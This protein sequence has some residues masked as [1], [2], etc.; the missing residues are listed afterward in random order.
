MPRVECLRDVDSL[1]PL[2]R[3]WQSL[4]HDDPHASV[5]QTPD[6][7]LTWQRYY[8]SNLH[9][10]A[11]Y[12]GRELIAFAPMMTCDLEGQKTLRFLGAPFNDINAIVA[13]REKRE[14]ALRAMLEELGEMWD[15]DT[16][17]WEDVREPH[18]VLEWALR[19]GLTVDV[20]ESP[21]PIIR[22]D[23][24]A[25]VDDQMSASRRK[26]L[27][28]IQNRALRELG[29]TAIGGDVRATAD[30]IQD[31]LALRLKSWSERDRLRDVDLQYRDSLHDRF[32]GDAATALT[33]AK[34]ARVMRLVDSERRLLATNLLLDHQGTTLLYY[35]AF[36]PC[37]AR[38]SPGLL[39]DWICIRD[40]EGR[41]FRRFDYGRG[42]E[43]YKF[44]FPATLPQAS[45]LTIRRCDG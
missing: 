21:C 26:R 15:W 27:R 28:Y 13:R 24:S 4:S 44:L 18:A 10:L 31:L 32:L 5:F 38:Y 19:T 3:A 1:E 37:Y 12:E 39:L 6:W 36:D 16:M 33:S 45:T 7:L 23:P 14:V 42:S 43:A 9:C 40:A 30:D 2:S 29:A 41:G 11:I 35:K 8:R 22:L 34:L 25:P 17:L 20:E